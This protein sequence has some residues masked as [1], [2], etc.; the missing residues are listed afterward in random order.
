MVSVASG[1]QGGTM[2]PAYDAPEYGSTRL[3]APKRPLIPLTQTLTE[4]HGPVFG[5]ER[6]GPIDADLTRQH[7][8][9]PL[10][11]RI[12]VTGRLLDVDGRPIPGQLVEIWQA[13]AAGR[14][15]HDADQHPAPLDPNFSGGGRCLS[16]PD[17]SY[18]FVTIK[19]GAYPWKNHANAWRPAHIHFSVFG[20][21]FSER[22][23]TQMYFP[24]DPLLAHDPIFRSVRDEQARSR[25]VSSFDLGSTEEEWALGYRFDVVIGSHLT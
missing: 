16:G 13:N 7:G 22:L 19:P 18:R 2:D 6:I 8:G 1:R 11:E 15:A 14:Y 10:G 23:I 9:E 5:D 20:R 25:L 24:G 21:A 3:R 17:G 12:I 4:R